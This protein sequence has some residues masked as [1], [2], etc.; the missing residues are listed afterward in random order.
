MINPNIIIRSGEKYANFNEFY[1]VNEFY[2]FRKNFYILLIKL[3]AEHGRNINV[4]FTLN[5]NYIVSENKRYFITLKDLITYL[6][7]PV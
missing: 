5:C 7:L 2:V 3:T 1:T 6:L 4:I